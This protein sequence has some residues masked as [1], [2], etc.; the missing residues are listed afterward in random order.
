MHTSVCPTTFLIKNKNVFYAIFYVFKFTYYTQKHRCILYSTPS[1]FVLFLI[2][3]VLFSTDLLQWSW[4]LRAFQHSSLTFTSILLV[5]DPFQ[6]FTCPL[7]PVQEFYSCIAGPQNVHVCN[8]TMYTQIALN[9]L[10][11]TSHFT[12]LPGVDEGFYFSMIFSESV[13]S[14]QNRQHPLLSG[15]S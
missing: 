1:G 7:W 14:K 3:V 15:N 6:H 10:Q 5:M 8:S 4:V 2:L 9:Q 12:L 11:I 13:I